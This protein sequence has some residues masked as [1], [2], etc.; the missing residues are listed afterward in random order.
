MYHLRLPARLPA[1]V[2][3]EAH[4]SS[5][6]SG[7]SLKKTLADENAKT[8]SLNK[9]LPLKRTL[10]NP[11]DP[12][13]KELASVESACVLHRSGPFEP[14]KTSPRE[15]MRLRRRGPLQ[16]QSKSSPK[17]NVDRRRPLHARKCVNV[18]TGPVSALGE[19]R[20]KRENA[21]S[22]RCR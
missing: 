18:M 13:F 22:G 2:F 19:D 15:K 9:T 5:P 3:P 1:K 12:P 20:P 8:P 6:N 4:A 16:L 17:E 10:E 14:S 21:A 7:L 11:R